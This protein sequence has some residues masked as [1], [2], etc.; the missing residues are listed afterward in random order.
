MSIARLVSALVL[1]K[2]S[3]CGL[4]R[5]GSGATDAAREN[6]VPREAGLASKA[7][8][9]QPIMPTGLIRASAASARPPAICTAQAYLLVPVLDTHIEPEVSTT[10]TPASAWAPRIP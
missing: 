7:R 5:T 1:I 4:R 3:T 2:F 9:P 6:A 8:S 10:D